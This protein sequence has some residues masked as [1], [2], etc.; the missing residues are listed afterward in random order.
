MEIYRENYIF[1]CSPD[2]ISKQPSITA[3]GDGPLT[4]VFFSGGVAR[5]ELPRRVSFPAAGSS[6][7]GYF[8]RGGRRLRRRPRRRF[9]Q[10]FQRM[11]APL[12]RISKATPLGTVVE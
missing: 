3:A 12:L 6:A 7:R 11:R 1:Y 9:E 4:G 5:E 8:R 10:L 2:T